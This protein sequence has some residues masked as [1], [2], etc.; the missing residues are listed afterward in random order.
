MCLV[1]ASEGCY[2]IYARGREHYLL[3]TDDDLHIIC[4]SCMLGN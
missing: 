2:L 4:L 3:F 1:F